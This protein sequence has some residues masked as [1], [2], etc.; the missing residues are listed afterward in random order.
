[1][2]R[3]YDVFANAAGITGR[4]ELFFIND[5][6]YFSPTEMKHKMLPEVKRGWIEVLIAG[7]PRTCKTMIS[8]FLHKHYKIGD[9]VAGSSSVSRA[10][11]TAGITFFKNK[12]QISWGKIPMND[13]GM[14]IIDEFSEIDPPTLFDLTPVRSS[15]VAKIDKIKSGQVLARVRKIMLSNPRGWKEEEQREYN[16]GIQF[17][18]DLCLQDRVLARFDLAFV[19]R[20][21][22]VDV[23]NFD[24]KYE[25]ISTEFTEYQCRHLIMWAYSR[26]PEDVEYEDGFDDC[27]N[28]VQKEMM[29]KYHPS[30]Q[31]VNQEMRAKLIRMSIS[32]AT[33]LY[34]TSKD[35][36]NKIF[37][38]KEHLD[39]V[40]KFLNFLYDHENMKMDQYSAMKKNAETLGDM[41][42]MMNICEYIDLN[43]LFREEEFTERAIHQ[44]FYDY[45]H[46]VSRAKMYMP[47]AK[48]DKFL[49][50][51]IMVHE[52]NQKLL[53]ILTARNCLVRTRR[54]T[55]K[56]TT[57]FNS[58]LA[59][60]MKLGD[61]A[62]KS[63][64]LELEQNKNNSAVIKE[65]EKNKRD[66]GGPEKR[67]AS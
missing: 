48:S 12:P 38:K 37:V 21:G 49:N 17:L 3:R 5:L 25:E 7:D 9:I 62:E 41:R 67:E 28:N 15:G 19:V 26:K 16:Y 59:E 40:V 51:K 39:H 60:R 34:S 1:M 56:K 8:E 33:M 2:E 29:E 63:Y 35:D 61:N 32:L 44:I 18:R 10:G 20:R 45:L 22:D 64:I 53:G 30:T 57:M 58:W 46:L 54:G 52:A 55:Y 66:D 14:I 65:C 50:T 24:S 47:N 13:G 4:K 23:N 31:L 36:W 27:V 42:F 43:P 6:A 11:L